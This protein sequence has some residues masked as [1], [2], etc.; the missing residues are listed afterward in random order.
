MC[1]SSSRNAVWLV[2]RS[3]LTTCPLSLIPAFFI[4]FSPSGYGVVHSL[5]FTAPE[6]PE[7]QRLF[8]ILDY[9]FFHHRQVSQMREPRPEEL[10]T[11]T[12]PGIYAS[13]HPTTPSDIHQC[14]QW[15]GKRHIKRPHNR[16]LGRIHGHLWCTRGE[17]KAVWR[18]T[19]ST[20]KDAYNTPEKTLA[21][22]H[23]P[24]RRHR[25]RAPFISLQTRE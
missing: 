20:R 11:R 18:S 21:S 2:S 24:R 25:N 10:S 23:L 12:S 4:L 6:E 13:I 5:S 7:W 14:A 8:F 15:R 22:P 19:S 1:W 16:P 3:L 9:T 17:I